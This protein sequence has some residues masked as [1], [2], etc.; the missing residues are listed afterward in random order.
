MM[1]IN[2]ISNTR[3]IEDDDL[4]FIFNAWLKSN[5]NTRDNTCINN[6]I[7]YDNYKRIIANILRNSNT[8]ILCDKNDSSQIFGFINYSDNVIN[9]IYIKYPY[10][11]FKMGKHLLELVINNIPSDIPI[12]ITHYNSKVK[13]TIDKYNLIYNPYLLPTNKETK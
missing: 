2:K 11:K 4:N 13:R 10:R 1:S 6:T 12:Y 3:N 7:Y 9:Y 8:I 5:R